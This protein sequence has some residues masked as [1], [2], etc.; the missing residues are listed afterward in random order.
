MILDINKLSTSY[1]A[2]KD[3]NFVQQLKQGCLAMQTLWIGASRYQ[4]FWYVSM[5]ANLKS[6]LIRPKMD[7]KHFKLGFETSFRELL[8]LM[9]YYCQ[10]Q[11]IDYI[12]AEEP[13]PFARSARAKG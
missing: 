2:Y 12:I 13:Y 1:Y 8:T 6:T 9:C 5:K 10:N 7:G 3:N 11:K 4:L